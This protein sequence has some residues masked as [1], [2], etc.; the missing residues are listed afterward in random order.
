MVY[1]TLPWYLLGGYSVQAIK[2]ADNPNVLMTFCKVLSLTYYN[3]HHIS[4]VLYVMV[5]TVG[6]QAP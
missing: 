3:S 4:L 1:F 5:R 2:S 6:G